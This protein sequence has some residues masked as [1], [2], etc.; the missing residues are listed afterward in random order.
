M[1]V[2]LKYGSESQSFDEVSIRGLDDVDSVKFFVVAD[3]V[4]IDGSLHQEVLAFRRVITLDLG[5]ILNKTDRVWL[6]G[7]FLS[8]DK[9]VVTT[10]EDVPVILSD[11]GTFD[12]EW[13]DNC[14]LARYYVITCE[15]KNA[16]DYV[17]S[18]WGV[19]N[20]WLTWGQT[21]ITP[22]GD[23]AYHYMDLS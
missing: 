1:G 17:P 10:G 14:E 15:E 21:D 5:V 9:H 4:L 22:L 13:I 23:T 19:A 11:A 18:S 8:D 2:T 3:E 12:N 20:A 7:C 6:R 16:R